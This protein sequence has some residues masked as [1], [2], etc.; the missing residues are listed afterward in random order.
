MACSKN[1]T[2]QKVGKSAPGR[3]TIFLNRN[4]LLL[5]KSAPPWNP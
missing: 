4:D 2:P 1:N 5:I 3:K